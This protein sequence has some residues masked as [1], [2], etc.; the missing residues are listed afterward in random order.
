MQVSQAGMPFTAE[1]NP[2]KRLTSKKGQG[3]DMLLQMLSG[4]NVAPE[5]NN[6]ESFLGKPMQQSGGAPAY[7]PKKYYGGLYSMYGGRRVRGGLL[8]E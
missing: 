2:Y 6:L 3:I 8:G 4:A 5:E 7:D 1:M